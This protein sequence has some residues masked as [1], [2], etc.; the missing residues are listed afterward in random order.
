MEE[1]IFIDVDEIVDI[2]HD[3]IERYGGD[4]GIRAVGLLYSA[5]SQPRA[6][7]GGQFLHEDL[8]AMAG[9]YLFHLVQNHPFVDGNKRVGTVADDVF[10]QLNGIEIPAAVEE[11]LVEMTLA[12]ASRQVDKAGVVQVLRELAEGS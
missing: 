8:F 5:L 7:F 4:P 3:Q 2:H 1:P 12:V 11:R 10:L 9:A 6:S